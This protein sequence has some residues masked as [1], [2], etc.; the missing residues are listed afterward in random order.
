M[1]SPLFA[2]LGLFVTAVFLLAGQRLELN[3]LELDDIP[4][5]HAFA[6]GRFAAQPRAT[7]LGDAAAA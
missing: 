4:L 5:P 7:H 2:G 6:I 1:T 3:L